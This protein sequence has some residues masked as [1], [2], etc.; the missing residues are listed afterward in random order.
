MVESEVLNI[1]HLSVHY[2]TNIDK[3]VYE[4]KLKPGTGTN[5]YGIDVCASLGFP[6]EFIQRAKEIL[7]QG[8]AGDT[9]NEF[10]KSRK[11]RYNSKVYVDVCKLCG[12]EE[13][14]HQHHVQEQNTAVNGFIGNYSKNDERNLLSLCENCHLKKIHGEGKEIVKVETLNSVLVTTK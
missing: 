1:S 10:V 5:L 11:S 8:P 12:S 13:N 7:I 3:L 14:V 6:S 2:D 4:R 9:N